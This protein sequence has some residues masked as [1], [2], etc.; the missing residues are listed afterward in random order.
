MQPGTR[1]YRFLALMM[2]MKTTSRKCF[3]HA[4]AEEVE[5]SRASSVDLAARQRSLSPRMKIPRWK[6]SRPRRSR[7]K[8][9]R[10]SWRT[11]T[12]STGAGRSAGSLRLPSLPPNASDA[13]T[14]ARRPLPS[15]SNPARDR[16]VGQRPESLA[17]P[18]SASQRCVLPC[19]ESFRSPSSASRH[20]RKIP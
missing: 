6:K 18:L 15:A 19:R 4:R 10:T 5:Q 1:A 14:A 13:P 7:R 17:L 20:G 2:R 11:R 3:S 12:R 16:V 9:R 8:T